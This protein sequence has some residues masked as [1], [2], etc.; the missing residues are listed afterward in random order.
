M[1]QTPQ[2][3]ELLDCDILKVAHHASTTSSSMNFLKAVSAEIA[4]IT[5]RADA[6]DDYLMETV[7]GRLTK[8]ESRIYD[9]RHNGRIICTQSDGKLYVNIQKTEK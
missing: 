8:L 9:T 1:L 3:A 2:I 5:A 4:L 6:E 7:V